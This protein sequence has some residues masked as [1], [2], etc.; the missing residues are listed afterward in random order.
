MERGNLAKI[1]LVET[2]EVIKFL[3]AWVTG[4]KKG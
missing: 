4:E 1:Y 2:R 3:A